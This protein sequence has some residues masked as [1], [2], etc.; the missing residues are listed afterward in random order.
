MRLQCERLLVAVLEKST[1]LSQ[2]VEL[3]L[4]Y[5]GPNDLSSRI[6]AVVA[7]MNV[8]NT[9][10]IESAVTTGEWLLA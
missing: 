8:K 3:A 9:S 5:G 7:Q 6:M 10:G 4:A 2:V 1:D